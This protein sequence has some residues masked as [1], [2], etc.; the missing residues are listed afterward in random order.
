MPHRTKSV[1]QGNEREGTTPT[2]PKANIPG[3]P[4]VSAIKSKSLLLLGA[5]IL[6]LSAA[7]PLRQDAER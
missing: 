6:V 1:S 4:N 2:S 3:F 7:R 5:S